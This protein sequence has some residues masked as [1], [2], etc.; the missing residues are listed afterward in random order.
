[1]VDNNLLGNDLRLPRLANLHTLTLNKNQ[2]SFGA[3][4]SLSSRRRSDGFIL[5]VITE[6]SVANVA[7]S[8]VR[9]K[10][11]LWQSAARG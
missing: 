10:G 8:G 9:F 2:I 7:L 5:F 6:G 4:R 1:M 11:E 3:P